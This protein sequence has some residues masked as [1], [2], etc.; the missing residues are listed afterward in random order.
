MWAATTRA[1]VV[2]GLRALAS[3]VTVS[4]PGR[5]ANAVALP[6]AL[7][8]TAFRG[9][10]TAVSRPKTVM[11]LQLGGLALKLP[12]SILLV[13]GA[14]GIGLPARGVVG[15]RSHSTASSLEISFR[16]TMS[17]MVCV[18]N[19]RPLPRLPENLPS[20]VCG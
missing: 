6:P 19:G 10:N 9:F 11:K 15:W 5:V 16:L 4:A 7:L 13:Y 14:P 18:S 2:P 20:D 17:L 1:V 3:P 8:F 12:L